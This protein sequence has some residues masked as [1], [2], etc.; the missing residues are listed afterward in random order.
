MAINT[1]VK[2]Y[3]YWHRILESTYPEWAVGN[4]IGLNK[5]ENKLNLVDDKNQDNIKG[6]PVMLEYFGRTEAESDTQKR[7]RQLFE[8][9]REK[10]IEPTDEL[11]RLAE[12]EGWL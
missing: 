3:T 9:C 7:Q 6:F 10:E 2:K 12:K 1:G 5:K 8:L 11:K 4:I